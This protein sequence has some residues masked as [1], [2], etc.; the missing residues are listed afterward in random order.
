MAYDEALAARIRARVEG[1]DGIFEKKMFGG[2]GWT[3]HGNMATGCHNDG[4]LMIRCSP[5]DH[6][7][8]VSEDGV[9]AIERGGKQMTGWILVDNA[10]VADDAQLARWVDRG[11]AYAR[12][13]PA[14]KPKKPKAKKKQ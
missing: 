11:V 2:I 10:V 9:G 12:S 5:E 8:F 6:P 7:G 1:I 4:R 14:K 3:I 13:M